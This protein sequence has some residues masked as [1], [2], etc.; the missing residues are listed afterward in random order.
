[1]AFQVAS[2]AQQDQLKLHLEGMGYTDVSDVKNRGYFDSI[3]V[4]TPSG[5]MFEATVT[6]DDGFTCDEARDKLG[7]EV[8]LAPQLKMTREEMLSQLGYL[9]D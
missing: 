6:H 9:K 7:L 5:A 8:M 3:Y 2:H 1:M 4:R